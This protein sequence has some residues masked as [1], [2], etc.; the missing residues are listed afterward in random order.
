VAK[1]NLQTVAFEQLDADKKAKVE[2]EVAEFIE[3]MLTDT[4]LNFAF[5]VPDSKINI[6]EGE[7]SSINY[8]AEVKSIFRKHSLVREDQNIED[9]IREMIAE[10]YKMS[11]SDLDWGKIAIWKQEMSLAEDEVAGIAIPLGLKDLHVRVLR[12][13]GAINIVLKNIQE[14]D[15]FKAFVSAGR[16]ERVEGEIKKFLEEVEKI[17]N[18]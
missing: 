12:I 7:M 10:I 18:K 9:G 17:K 13:T 1:Y 6:R 5:N 4:G 2:Q 15:Y 14:E 8:L 11:S 3:S 16:A